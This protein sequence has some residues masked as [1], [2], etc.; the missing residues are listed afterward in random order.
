MQQ[1][2][3]FPPNQR[4]IDMGQVILGIS[5]S[6]D[7]FVAG[8]ND[9]VQELFKWYFSGDHEIPVQNDRLVLKVSAESAKVLEGSFMGDKIGAMLT[10][11]KNFDGASAWGGH[12]PFV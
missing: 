11:R 7:G 4:R 6:L 5:M 1:A 10:G 8:P 2:D 12:P 3:S 9:D